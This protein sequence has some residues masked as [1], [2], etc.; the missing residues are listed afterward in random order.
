MIKTNVKIF[1]LGTLIYFLSTIINTLLNNEYNFWLTLLIF[2]VIT[3]VLMLIDKVRK[4]SLFGQYVDESKDERLSYIRY[5]SSAY[6]LL[7]GFFMLVIMIL[8]FPMSEEVRQALRIV[9]IVTSVLYVITNLVI[10]RRD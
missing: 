8:F 2:A 10:E 3:T 5:K 1:L 6:T 9:V 4:N 7:L